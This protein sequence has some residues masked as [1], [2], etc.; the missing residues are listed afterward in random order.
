VDILLK[1][2]N[3]YTLLFVVPLY[4][5]VFGDLIRWVWSGI[6]AVELDSTTL[7]IFRSSRQPVQSVAISEIGSVRITTSFDGPAVEILLH[8]AT[9][10]KLLWVYF[11]TGPRIHIPQGPFG[12]KDFAEFIEQISALRPVAH[13]A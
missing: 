4:A 6:R 5:Y 2:R 7:K 8:G 13:Q 9:T 11:F 1:L 3:F 10:K 12:K